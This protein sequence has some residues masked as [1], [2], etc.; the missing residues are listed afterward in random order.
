MLA[1]KMGV[2]MYAAAIAE[3]TNN[4]VREVLR[5]HLM[6]A[7]DMQEKI[8][9]YSISKRYYEPFNIKKQLTM[10]MEAVDKVLEME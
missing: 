4:E 8:T 1:A 10:D 2:K 9:N 3:S 5:K 7:I 6:V